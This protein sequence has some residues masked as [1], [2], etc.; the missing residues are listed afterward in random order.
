MYNRLALFDK[1][2]VKCFKS[3]KNIYTYVDKVFNTCSFEV[4]HAC[5]SSCYYKYL[6]AV[7]CFVC[8]RCNPMDA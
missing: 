3:V 4:I 1:L 8:C 6:F 5:R 7:N 2:C